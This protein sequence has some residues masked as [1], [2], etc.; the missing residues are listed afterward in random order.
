MASP[1]RS[2]A[3]ASE[4]R[5]AL[6]PTELLDDTAPEQTFGRLPSGVA[7]VE[8]LAVHGAR[9]PLAR[10]IG[11]TILDAHHPAA[12]T[13]AVPMRLFAVASELQ[14]GDWLLSGQVDDR[15]S[16][17]WPLSAPSLPF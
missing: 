11:E 6:A 16:P 10:D 7:Q 12:I 4:G 9:A 14:R 2:G 1:G 13:L 15:L 17:R 8:A 5:H 3:F